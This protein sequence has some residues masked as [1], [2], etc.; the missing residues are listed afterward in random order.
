MKPGWKTTE[1]GLT[2]V[3]MI[4]AALDSVLVK[5]SRIEVAV[6]FGLALL[7]TLGYTASR[8][9]L[10]RADAATPPTIF[11]PPSEEVTKP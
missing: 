1:F 2:L 3:W 5:G 7:A 11:P 8:T 4:L 10:K 6:A 9:V